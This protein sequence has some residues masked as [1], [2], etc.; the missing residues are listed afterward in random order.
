MT[1]REKTGCKQTTK[2]L[3]NIFK[4]YFA[5]Q[6]K[7]LLALSV[8]MNTGRTPSDDKSNKTCRSHENVVPGKLPHSSRWKRFASSTTLHGLRHVAGN[9]H[10]ISKRLIWL[11]FLG[12]ATCTFLYYLSISLNK[13]FSRPIKTV[14]SQET[15][16]EGLK[17]PAVTICNLNTVMRSKVDMADED[18]NFVK[19]GLNISGCSETREVRGNLTCGQALICVY[20]PYGAALVKGCN[21][22]VRQKLMNVLNRSSHR[23]FNEEEFFTKYGHDIVGMSAS[24]LYCFFMQTIRCSEKD[25]VPKLTEYGICFTFNSGQNGF[26]RSAKYEGP[27]FGL[28]ILLDVQTNESTLSQFSSGLKVIVHDQDTFVNRYNG[29]NIVPGTHA[30]VGVKLRKVSCFK[31]YSIFY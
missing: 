27:D 12:I 22:T 17:F 26:Y 24:F 15:P 16:T 18:E 8:A 25:F 1:L 6:E 7:L 20:S 14:I 10:S 21:G 4:I 3:N 29:F 31:A 30:S 9:S 23:V 2:T 28:S 5:L 13:Y 11:I 19:M